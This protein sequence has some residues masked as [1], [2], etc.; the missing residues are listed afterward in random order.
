MNRVYQAGEIEGKAFWAEGIAY[1]KPR[2]ESLGLRKAKVKL[3]S[4][5]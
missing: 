1:A 4:R 3:L 5:V 2:K